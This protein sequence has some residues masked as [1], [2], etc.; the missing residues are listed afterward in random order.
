MTRIIALLAFALPVGAAAQERFY[1]ESAVGAL[2]T[3][4]ITARATDNDWATRC[5]LLINPNGVETGTECDRYPPPTEW[6]NTSGRA[7]GF[8]VGFAA[9]YHMGWLSTELEYRYRIAGH[10][11]YAPTAIGDEITL[12]KADQ[13]LER[14][15]GGVGDVS[16]HS[17]LANVVVRFGNRLLGGAD[18]RVAERVHLGIKL[19]RTH[20]GEFR[21]DPRE[22]DQLR[23]HESS[24]GR[25]ER[26]LYEVRSADMGAWTITVGLRYGI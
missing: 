23:S 21:S 20:Y 12:D 25:G 3:P 2:L 7:T 17:L 11:D 4:T 19:R 22:W 13:E 5:D 1:F 15:V 16:A 8:A 14:A 26:I 6:S 18:I 10:H 9:G 24:V